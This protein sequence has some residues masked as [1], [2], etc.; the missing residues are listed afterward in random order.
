[1]RINLLGII[2]NLST[3]NTKITNMLDFDSKKISI[4]E[5]N[6]N[7]VHVYYD[8][9][10]FFFFFFLSID[11]LK[12]YFEEH[13]DKN[14]IVGRVKD[15]DNIV[16]KDKKIKYLIIIFLSEYQEL[17]YT[18]ILKKISKDVNKNYVKIKFDSNDNEPL[19]I[20]INIHTL[21]LSVR[22]QRVYLN[23]C[24]YDQIQDAKIKFNL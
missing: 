21:V 20:L 7:K 14:N 13:D 17:M 15:K 22:Y 5:T 6:N 23:T 24:W 18:K 10:P 3:N 1:M 2:N 16:G 9:N 4:V 12:G 19:N 8:H 11:N